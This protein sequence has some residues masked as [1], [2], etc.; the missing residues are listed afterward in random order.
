MRERPGVVRRPLQP[1]AAVLAEHDAGRAGAHRARLHLRARQVLRAG[2][3]GAAAAGAGQHRRRAV[4]RRSPPGSACR[5]PTP[6]D[7]A[8]RRWRRAR[9][10]PRSGRPGRPTAGW[11]ASS[12]T[13]TATSPASRTSRRRVLAAGMVPL[14]IAAARRQARRRP[15]RAAHLRHRALG[16]VRRR[17]RRRRA[18][19]PRRTPSPPATPRRA[20]RRGPALDP[21]VV[22]LLE[23][24]SATPRRSAPG[25][26]ASRPWRRPASVVPPVS[27]SVTT[28]G[29]VRRAPTALGA[30]RVWERF[31]TMQG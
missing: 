15:R 13:P 2:D 22:L 16:R 11:S 18:R 7:V 20:S 17:A 19:R 24:A 26:T 27:S 12:S 5:R 10:C 4:R 30:H 14:V 1:G 9:R 6:T 23:E 8:R 25:A 29:R 3:Q 31:A 28:H 21:R